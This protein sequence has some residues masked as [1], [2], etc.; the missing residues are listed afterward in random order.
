MKN[1]FK[2]SYNEYYLPASVDFSKSLFNDL[3]YYATGCYTEV[4]KHSVN[5]IRPEN[6]ELLICVAG[7]GF[8]ET[9]EIKK[10]LYSG[11]FFFTFKDIPIKY[12]SSLKN[13]WTIYYIQFNG[14]RIVEFLSENNVT[15]NNSIFKIKNYFPVSDIFDMLIYD[16]KIANSPND[17]YYCQSLF[18]QL[19][20]KLFL[21]I[22]S[23][24]RYDMNVENAI[25]FIN[26]NLHMKISLELLARNL[27]ISKSHLSRIFHS[28]VGISF[29]KYVTLQK[30]NFSKNLLKQ[31]T[32]NISEISQ[33]IGFENPLFYSNTFK[34]IVKASPS[35]YRKSH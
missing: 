19:L 21:S 31:T 16:S 23:E 4:S 2:E 12:G 24:T 22:G 9:T 15:P 34:K 25:Q 5:R 35:E 13:P 29:T 32:Y 11:D 26:N 17:F 6:Y 3:H 8:V 33:L 18:Y 28:Q 30:I 1:N 14:N 7:E 10:T 20:F 27:G